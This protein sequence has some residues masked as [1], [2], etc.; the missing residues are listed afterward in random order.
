MSFSML[1]FLFTSYWAGVGA[2]GEIDASNG[3]VSVEDWVSLKV[4][5]FAGS[6]L[7]SVDSWLAVGGSL[8]VTL[9]LF[10]CTPDQ[11]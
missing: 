3:V 9:V 11:K 1:I 8:F 4:T 2:S 5:L 6:R 10:F 7:L